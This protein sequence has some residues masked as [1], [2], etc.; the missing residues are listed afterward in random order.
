MDEIHL[1]ARAKINLALDVLG[2][3]PNGYHEVRMVMQSIG[4]Y[5]Q[6]TL[7]KKD[8][9]G[10]EIHANMAFLEQPEKNLA[11]RAYEMLREEFD[12]PGGLCMNL[13]KTI[14]IAAG[15]AGGSSDAAS[16]LYGVNR[17]YDLRLSE[18]EL[19]E[20]G[21]KLG[22]DVPFCL[23]RG[24]VLAEGIGEK[25]TR[26]PACPTCYLVT[27]KPPI[28]VSTK[29][30]YDTLDATPITKHPNVDAMIAALE[31]GDLQGVV[32]HMGN[33][34]E[35]VTIPAYP[36]ITEIK[37]KLMEYG[38]MGAMMSGSGPTVFGIFQDKEVAQRACQSLRQDA[39]AAQVYLTDMFTPGNM[40]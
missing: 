17:L 24:T 40:G 38:A 12:L 16:V 2:T 10:L 19:R 25:L 27:A 11:A 14:P 6:I 28:S 5:D 33:V 37:Q 18:E 4:T 20:R 22:A 21:K 8:E 1:K 39:L 26:L 32:D 31:A 29:W 13:H 3:L 35:D 36:V 15:T 7:K 23:M 30:V 34:L 9:P